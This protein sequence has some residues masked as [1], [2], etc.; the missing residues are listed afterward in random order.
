MND[1]FQKFT[2]IAQGGDPTPPPA[3]PVENRPTT[4]KIDGITVTSDRLTDLDQ[5]A[6]RTA[7]VRAGLADQLADLRAKRDDRRSILSRLRDRAR[8][9][10]SA[11]ASQP[12]IAELDAE[13]ATLTARMSETEA[14]LAEAAS[15]AAVARTN[16]KTALSFAKD[17]GLHIPA[18]VNQEGRA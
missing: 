12:Q 4:M 8:D 9:P 15:A 5:I 11:G 16:L 17:C 14:E 2:T 18:G 7:A 10:R 3:P 6:R 1:P 13:I